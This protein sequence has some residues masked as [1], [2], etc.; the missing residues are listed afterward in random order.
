MNCYRPLV[1]FVKG[2]FSM[3]TASPMPRNQRF[4]HQMT[5]IAS[6]FHALRVRNFRLFVIG[7]GISLIGTWMQTTAQAWLVVTL[8]NS[9]LALGLVTTLQFLPVMFLSLYG[10][11]LADRLP[12]RRTLLVTQ[13]LLMIQAGIFA[14][15]VATGMIQL[16]QVYVLAFCQ[17]LV[18]AIDV[19]V[20]QSF[21]V[22]MVGREELPNAVALNSMT[23]NGARIIGPAIAG[24]LIAKIGIAPALAL[25]AISFIAVIIG[26]AMMRASEL[27]VV[28]KRPREPVLRQLRE[29]I[30]YAWK[31]PQIRVVIITVAAIGTFGYNF[32]VTVPL[33]ANFVLKT[34]AQGYG[35]LSAAFGAGALIAAIGTA[36]LKQQ[37]LQ[38]ML[39]GAALFSLA[40]AIASLTTLFWLSLALFAGI[41]VTSIIFSTSS[42]TLMQLNTPDELRGRVLSLF[43]LLIGG[44]TPIG[45]FLTGALADRF[46]VP[47]ALVFC[48][49]ACIIGV[50]AATIYR[51][52]AGYK[53]STELFANVPLPS[54]AAAGDR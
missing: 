6:G 43:V 29:G 5:R 22:E 12:K 34:D 36:Y 49:V 41:G 20:R 9:P 47:F 39:I 33:V 45:G 51:L 54:P 27:H 32:T 11:V 24:V 10:G 31:T 52:S 17:G 1:L 2:D 19:P 50:I 25:N 4:N 3:H 37:T 40:L 53:Q 30:A 35:L 44:T 21:F 8:T 48:A 18:Q 38:R 46:G 13:T 26:L 28:E 23:F 14:I 16:W 42:N 15:L 7:Q